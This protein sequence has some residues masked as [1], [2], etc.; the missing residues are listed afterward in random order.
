MKNNV[1]KSQGIQNHEIFRFD[2]FL[3]MFYVFLE[4]LKQKVMIWI[5]HI[6]SQLFILS[7][8]RMHLKILLKFIFGS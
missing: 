3:G 8:H 4:I 7:L 2:F 6:Y 5:F 1:S